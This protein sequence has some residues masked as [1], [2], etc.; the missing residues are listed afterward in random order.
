MDIIAQNV[1]LLMQRDSLR[2]IPDHP[3]PA[4]YAFKW[5]EPGDEQKWIEP[6]QAGHSPEHHNVIG[7]KPDFLITFH[8]FFSCPDSLG[9]FR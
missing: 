8:P 6:T 9:S 2:G 7:S 5:Y 1:F 4:H 3:L